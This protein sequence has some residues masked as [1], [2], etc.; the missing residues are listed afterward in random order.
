[1]TDFEGLR[2]DVLAAY[3]ALT[4]LAIPRLAQ[5]RLRMLAKS[6]D[7]LAA[8]RFYVV[9]CGEFRRGKSSLL[10]ALVERP[11]LFPVDTDITTSAVITL[12][13][14]STDSAA[15]VFAA[16]DP[17][18]AASA[19]DS[20]DIPVERAAEFVTEQ[21]NPGNAKNVLRIDMGAPI[22]QLKSGLV[23]VDTPGLGSLNPAHNAATRAFLRQADAVLFVASAVEPLGDPELAILRLALRY[24]PVVITALTKIDNIVSATP[25]V[26]EARR[27]IAATT[28][29]APADLVI[30]PVS[31]FRKREALEE[32]DD[33]LLAESGFPQLEAELWGGLAVTCG[34]AQV[35]A[36]LD[37]MDAALDEATAPVEN[38]LAALRGD[39]AK[40]RAELLDKQQEYQRLKKDAAGWRRDLQRDISRATDPIYQHLD[41]DADDIREEFRE[42]LASPDVVEDPD[43]IVRRVA[44]GLVDAAD[45]AT[46]DLELAFDR[47]ADRYSAVTALSITVTGTAAGSIKP[48]VSLRAP[49]KV[50]QRRGYRWFREI[51]AGGAAG[52]GAGALVGSVFP[53][54]GTAAGAV[55]G[56]LAGIFGGHRFHRK[57]TKERERRALVQDLKD[58]VQPKLSAGQRQL[59]SDITSQ[60]R[61]Y[62]QALTDGLENELTARGDAL[63]ASIKSLEEAAKRDAPAEA[64]RRRDLAREQAELAAMRSQLIVLRGR[65]DDLADSWDYTPA[66]NDDIPGNNA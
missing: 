54:V 52:A 3:L 2:D 56:F 25:V 11:G 19:R 14:A 26:A 40:A 9:V 60:V 62:S 31:S 44:D 29:V 13:W 7:R 57:V 1:M 4:A 23:L 24:S 12:Q 59:N 53:V 5:T 55:A 43:S 50:K 15:V 30:V 6:R 42:A 63:A 22:P 49:A 10:N 66:G 39:L 18:D 28:G 65:A 48:S 20:E 36:A 16:P 17:D 21:G 64:A 32:G 61:D 46:E 8:G 34:V 51:W 38:E 45:R 35:R 37:A 27:R 33:A 47:L 41:H 58:R